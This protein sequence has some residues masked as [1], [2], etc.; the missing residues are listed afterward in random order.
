MATPRLT[1][2]LLEALSDA[3]SSRLAGERGNDD[4]P[5]APKTLD[6]EDA[7]RWVAHQ[8]WKRTQGQ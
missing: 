3:L 1:T 4:D 7:E 6:Y 5:S 2:R 8:I